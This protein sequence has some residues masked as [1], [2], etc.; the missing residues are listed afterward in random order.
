MS[1][2]RNIKRRDQYIERDPARVICRL[3]LPG[4]SPARANKIIARILKL[5]NQE[6]KELLERI[7]QNFEERHKNIERV[8]E[9]HFQN[10][11]DLLYKGENPS[12]NQHQK[13]LLGACFSM[14]YAIESAA[15]FNPSIVLH[16][17]QSGLP[18]NSLRFI[19]SLRAV[20]EGHISSIVFR[21]GIIDAEGH[22]KFDPVSP[23]VDTPDLELNPVYEREFFRSK[24]REIG[25]C[26][27]IAS[28]I[29]DQLPETFNYHQ[30]EKIMS[31]LNDD[32]IF[33]P[34][35]QFECIHRINWL[36]NSNYRLDFPPEHL[37][38]ERV[39]FPASEIESGGIEDARFVQFHDESGEQIYYATYTAYNGR[40]I[41]PQLIETRDFEHFKVST[42]NGE[43]VQNKGLALFPRKIKGRYAM[44]SRQDGEN[45]YIMFS[46]KLHVWKESQIIQK[47][48]EPW[49]YIQIGNCGSPLETHRG[50]LVLTHGVGPMRVYSIGAILLD[51]DDPTKVIARMREPLLRPH[52]EQREGY[53][54]NVV[55]TCGAIFHLD[56]LIIPYS[57]SDVQAGV[58]NV[59]VDDL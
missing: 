6:A 30:L 53:V 16:P 49:E 39:I 7:L 33:A 36:V 10:V 13:L 46:D 56:E 19:M 37:I 23:H 38:S 5:T 25:E 40:S 54:P 51:R 12:L 28:H 42:L 41:M 31:E 59:P 24:L 48:V 29:L 50:W 44:L 26:N 34:E 21:S 17:N 45:N 11:A 14:E 52:E 57:M 18:K 55:Y 2:I 58:V 15:L 4:G 22:L 47:P 3:H 35:R 20:G 27:E 1:P 43:A 8:F 9:R 32:P